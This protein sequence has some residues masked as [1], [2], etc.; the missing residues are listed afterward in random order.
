MVF[1]CL[2]SH[3]GGGAEDCLLVDGA[4]DL[5]GGA[6]EAEDELAVVSGAG[7]M[8]QQLERDMGG[9][10][11]GK[12]QHI[13]AAAGLGGGDFDF[14]CDGVECDIGLEFAFDVDFE[15]LA[16]GFGLGE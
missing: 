11:V 14:G 8:L 9:V 6:G 16:V 1:D 5:G 13:G 2:N 15:K 10:E 4:G 3:C 12:D 7:D